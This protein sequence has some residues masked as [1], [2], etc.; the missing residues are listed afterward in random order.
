MTEHESPGVR[1]GLRGRRGRGAQH[2]RESQSLWRPS[3]RFHGICA[4]PVPCAY[5]VWKTNRDSLTEDCRPLRARWTEFH[6]RT[7]LHRFEKPHPCQRVLCPC[8]HRQFPSPVHALAGCSKVVLQN[9][10]GSAED[11]SMDWLTGLSSRSK[12]LADGPKF[13]AQGPPSNRRS[14]ARAAGR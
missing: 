8:G 9:C 2:R 3:G 4:P 5:S 11:A 6:N 13:F 12:E 10:S 1:V 7:S 14:A